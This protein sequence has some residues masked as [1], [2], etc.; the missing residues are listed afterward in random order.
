MM[1]CRGEKEIVVLYSYCSIKMLIRI[2]IFKISILKVYL[3]VSTVPVHFMAHET[4]NSFSH[5]IISAFMS[6]SKKYII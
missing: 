2:L 1:F 5:Y 4:Q 3:S 6:L